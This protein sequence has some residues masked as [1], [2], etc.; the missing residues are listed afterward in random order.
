MIKKILSKYALSKFFKTDLAE[1]RHFYCSI[2]K[3]PQNNKVCEIVCITYNNPELVKHQF[4]LLRKYFRGAYNFI[5]ADNSSDENARVEI[6]KYCRSVHLGYISLPTNP[7][8]TGSMSHAASINWMVKNY[9]EFKQPAYFGFI[10]HDVFPVEPFS[11]E[12]ILNKQDIYGLL[13]ERGSLWYLWAGFCFFA[14]NKIDISKL[15]FMPGTVNGVALDTGG[16]NW[17]EVYSKLNK[18]QITFPT[19]TY[20]N[21]REGNVAQ[22]DKLE[23]I[24]QWVHS[25]NGSYWM[26]VEKKEHL[27][28]K[29]LNQYL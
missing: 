11:I 22:S 6:E 29:F 8:K 4:S 13:Q 17:N 2:D 9:I 3:Y 7:Y 14:Y 20:Q 28:E 10:D 27:L 15:D 12:S 16:M 24:G 1:V 21:L 19:Q 18:E 26:K 23:I 25:F 5:I